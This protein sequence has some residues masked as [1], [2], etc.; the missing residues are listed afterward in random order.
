MSKNML[1][2]FQCVFTGRISTPSIVFAQ[3]HVFLLVPENVVYGADRRV[4]LE[5]Q[6]FGLVSVGKKA[7]G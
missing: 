4:I 2:W 5:V 1:W 3:R 6:L 7:I